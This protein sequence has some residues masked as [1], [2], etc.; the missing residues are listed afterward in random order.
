[1]IGSLV[2]A[3]HAQGTIASENL[4]PFD[5][6][7]WERWLLSRKAVRREIARSSAESSMKAYEHA[8][9]IVKASGK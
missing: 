1:M 7:R 8:V 5:P 9:Q 3:L 6:S 2:K 4:Q